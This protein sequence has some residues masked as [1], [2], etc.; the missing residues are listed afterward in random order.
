MEPFWDCDFGNPSSRHGYGRSAWAAIETARDQIA[1][2]A[3]AYPDR[4]IFTSGATESNFLSLIGRFDFLI[5]SGREASSIRIAVN[6]TEHPCV[7]YAI[8]RLR[9]R[10]ARIHY[11]HV[12]SLG[13]VDPSIFSADSD[14]DIV[15][16]MAANHET[17][18][19]QPVREITEL[20]DSS[21]TYFHC[22]AAQ[23]AAR[24][25][26][27]LNHW[28]V[29]AMS[30]SAHKLYGPKGAGA[31]L[32]SPDARILPLFD[33]S[34]E[35]G[36][37]GG[38]VNT[39]GAVGFGAAVEWISS[40]LTHGIEHEVDNRERLWEELSKISSLILRSIP[41]EYSLSNTLHIR[42]P[43]HKGERV[44]DALDRD[45]IACSSG[46][47][48]ASGASDASPVLKAMG[49]TEEES[50]EGIRFS[51]G[52][53]TTEAEIRAAAASLRRYLLQNTS[54]SA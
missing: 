8:E 53:N 54:R 28:K 26:G 37:R 27:G 3:D 47:A 34:Q 51:L 32:L 43:G 38:T 5:E 35:G 22:D 49:L 17:G 18:A 48:C 33:G 41:A 4:L 36:F 14:W 24:I 50:W 21:K 6:P 20:L 19:I 23:W 45:G 29:S 16:V 15:A 25:K 46:P 2:W 1:Q 31:L 40:Q 42:I 7:H 39:T 13:R 12:D 11:L 9:Q 30:L 52:I 10:G 44:V